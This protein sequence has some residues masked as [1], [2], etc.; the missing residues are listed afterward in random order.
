[1]PK[2]HTLVKALK[3]VNDKEYHTLVKAERLYLNAARKAGNAVLARKME[4][5][6]EEDEESQEVQY[7]KK[8]DLIGGTFPY[9]NESYSE[10]NQIATRW[11]H[12]RIV[13]DGDRT[14]ISCRVKWYL[15]EKQNES[16]ASYR[17]VATI[18][19]K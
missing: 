14:V 3:N 12:K 17:I 13:Q 5:Y 11:A 1:M 18:T 8:N 16:I 7:S 10:A 4:E 2:I 19:K 6:L 15:V 9:Y